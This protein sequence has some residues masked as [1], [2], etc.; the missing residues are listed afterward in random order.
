MKAC[1]G[2]SELSSLPKSQGYPD[3]RLS[4]SSGLHGTFRK[5]YSPNTHLAWYSSPALVASSPT[6]STVATLPHRPVSLL[7]LLLPISSRQRSPSPSGEEV[8]VDRT[9]L[10]SS[11]GKSL[12]NCSFCITPLTL[13]LDAITTE[14]S[15]SMVRFWLATSA[16]SSRTCTSST[17]ISVR[18]GV[19]G[20]PGGVRDLPREDSDIAAS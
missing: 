18:T 12:S 4:G 8:Q 19:H 10:R 5:L 1:V 3:N 20:V 11:P 13:S 6:P 2:L 9:P 7:P 15:R 16:F 14:L 17:E